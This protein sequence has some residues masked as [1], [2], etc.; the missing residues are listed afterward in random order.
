MVLEMVAM[1]HPE[2]HDL[3]KQ[4]RQIYAS[5]AVFGTAQFSVKPPIL[6]SSIDLSGGETNEEF[7]S[8][9]DAVHG[10]RALRD[11]V[12]RDLD[13]LEK[14]RVRPETA[15]GYISYYLLPHSTS[16]SSTALHLLPL[17]R[18]RRTRPI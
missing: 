15:C 10:L 2:L 9:Q 7:H 16:S 5:I 18:C 12:K 1:P 14:V 6:D 4:L 13:V 11:A 17:L 3:R 8:H